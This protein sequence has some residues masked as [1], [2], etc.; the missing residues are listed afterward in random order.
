MSGSEQKRWPVGEYHGCFDCGD[1]VHE[2][3]AVYEE[4]SLGSFFVICQGCST[5]T[6]NERSEE[7][8]P[9]A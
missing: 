2:D 5:E 3:H 1:E 8:P 4:R 7:V 6:D 9:G